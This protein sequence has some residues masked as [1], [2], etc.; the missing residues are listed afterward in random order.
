[1]PISN[2]T[3]RAVNL[4]RF[5][6][7]VLTIAVFS[8]SGYALH[9][10][11]VRKHAGQMLQSARSTMALGNLNESIEL[12]K[13]YI[14]FRPK[15]VPVLAEYIGILDEASKNDS[16]RIP[17]L[18]ETYERLLSAE[19]KR[20]EDRKKLIQIYLEA[21]ALTRANRHLEELMKQDNS[22]ASDPV[23]LE[24]YARA[25][26]KREVAIERYRAVRDTGKASHEAILRLVNLLQS[27][28]AGKESLAEAKALLERLV[29]DRPQDPS[30]RL[31][32]ARYYISNG[33]TTEAIRDLESAISNPD[34][35]KSVPIV[36]ILA[37]LHR[38]HRD[39]TAARNVLAQ[40]VAA[41]PDELRF[42]LIYADLLW[43]LGDK[44]GNDKQLQD[45]LRL[46][47]MD[48]PVAVDVLDRM[49]ER[50][51]AQDL[52]HIDRELKRRYS[53]KPGGYTD[54]LTGKHA[55]A[56]GNWS[57]AQG[58]LIHA[59]GSFT[60]QPRLL[61]KTHDALGQCARFANHPERMAACFTAALTADPLLESA[62]LGL[63]EAQVRLGRGNEAA[64]TFRMFAEHN[65]EARFMLARQAFEEQLRKAPDRRDWTDFEKALGLPPYTPSLEILK[66]ASL[67]IRDKRDDAIAA[68]KALVE[69][70]PGKPGGYLALA[71][72]QAETNPAEALVTLDSAEAK[73]GDKVGIRIAKANIRA[74]MPGAK[75]ENLIELVDDAA[76]LMPDERYALYWGVANA[77]TRRMKKSEE[78]LSLYRKAAEEKPNDLASRAAMIEIELAL[79][80]FS[81]A[82]VLIDELRMFDGADGP[83]YLFALVS[84]GALSLQPGEKAKLA[85]LRS[86]I[87]AVVMARPTWGRAALLA[88]EL[89]DAAGDSDAA[90]EKFR[91]AFALGERRPTAIQRLVALLVAKRRFDEARRVLVDAETTVGLSDDLR[92]QGGLLDAL[93][94]KPE[95]K[96]EELVKASAESK[97]ASDHLFRGQWF[98]L[99]GRTSDAVTAFERAVSLDGT[100]ADGWL[101]LVLATA[102][103]GNTAAANAAWER[104]KTALSSLKLP[105]PG[106]LPQWLGIGREALGDYAG[107][108]RIYTEGLKL[109]ANHPALLV[110]LAVL[111]QKLGRY[112]EATGSFQAL[113]ASNA[114]DSLKR[115]ARRELAFG[116]ISRGGSREMK[117]AVEL[118]NANV[119][120]EPDDLRMKGLVLSHDPYKRSEARG[121]ISQAAKLSAPS[122]YDAQRLADF[123]IRDN[124]ISSA[125]EILRD[126]NRGGK[127][128]P[129]GQLIILHY[130][131]RKLDKDADANATL[132]RIV[133]LA[134]GTWEATVEQAR[135][136]AAHG[137]K[138][139]AVKVVLEHP[140]AADPAFRLSIAAPA[141]VDL[142]FNTEVD[143]LLKNLVESTKLPERYPRYAFYLASQQR[144]TEAIRVAL[145]M[146]DAEYPAA[147]KARMLYSM[148]LSVPRASV[149][150]KAG[151]DRLIEQVESWMSAAQTKSPGDAVLVTL[152]GVIADARGQYETA[153]T[154]F[155]KA[156]ANDPKSETAA[157][158]LAYLLTVGPVPDAA[159]AEAII[160]KLIQESGPKPAMLDT[161]AAARMALGRLKEASADIE[162]AMVQLPTK[163]AYLFR[164]A[165]I[166]EKSGDL[167]ARSLAARK[168]MDLRLKKESLHPL[169]W[170]AFD[171]MFHLH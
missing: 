127:A 87:A 35:A 77:M 163:G 169:E 128:V 79:K 83:T 99:S 97:N 129:L 24:Q 33:Q 170:P 147:Q 114:S 44:A 137:E 94:E 5:T 40:A 46:A 68:A 113:L 9:R 82:D 96:A 71:A 141:L 10:F 53:G 134:P 3:R 165:Q 21:R 51:D 59:L 75:P 102:A 63:A 106:L 60:K 80:N 91:R 27:E 116:M 136:K 81:R 131:Q 52:L 26:P 121:L 171:R 25:A 104:A 32:R 48:D 130:L 145:A 65:A 86:Q 123:Y 150:D 42:R 140:R 119:P 105:D 90:L 78:A 15:E 69:Q 159:R 153:I 132:E 124:D 66:L 45:A 148:I 93:S 126:A 64:S 31:A 12:Y 70:Q 143:G 4:K 34:G 76:S 110:Q 133:K 111:T 84:R 54:Y 37:D 17:E 138:E 89:D 73:L 36:V 120:P 74:S 13:R 50:G 158:C 16:R 154:C 8:L 62:R 57:E 109:H 22:L 162:A 23:I 168:A 41:S 156:V 144:E 160:T 164:L 61:A 11:Q 7:L 14:N 122:Q 117:S 67:R 72:L 161:R 125:E 2:Y 151:W 103:T 107:A 43:V 139:E 135:A 6:L 1:M 92:R 38:Q 20:K 19:P 47:P 58:K 98:L 166:R 100:N 115:F 146:P 28:G 108:V 39:Y 95:A 29:S 101:G 149:P 30:A 55:L 18:Y 56:S 167:P 85:D 142:G 152:Q 157:N 118:L 88:A 112:D 49:I 155:E